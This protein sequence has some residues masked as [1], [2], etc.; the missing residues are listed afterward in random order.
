MVKLKTQK[1]TWFYTQNSYVY[2]H[3]S[4]SGKQNLLLFIKHNNSSFVR[5]ETKIF[6]V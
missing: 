2:S 4:I 1:Y 3:K 6:L 5:K